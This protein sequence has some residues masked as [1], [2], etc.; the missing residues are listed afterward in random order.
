MS[1]FTHLHVHSHYSLLDGLSKISELVARAKQMGM[2][3]LALTDHGVM[4]G[5]IEFYNSCLEAGIKPII[6][7]EAYIAPRSLADKSGKVDSDYFHLT[8]LAANDKG[9]K[10]LLKLT[11]IAHI[12]GYYYKPR[13]DLNVLRQ[14]SSGLIALSGCQ[15]GELARA[16][17]NKSD[18]EIKE[19]LKKYL[20]IFGAENFYIEIQR[21]SLPA[22]ALAKAGRVQDAAEQK[23]SQ[24]L[25]ALARANNLKIVATADC[26]YIYPNDAEA[27]DVLLCIGTARI[28]SDSNRMDM[29]GYDLSLKTGDEMLE[30]FQDIPESVSNTAEV[31]SRCDLKILTGQR[32]FPKVE[33]PAGK[34]IAEYLRELT[35][36]KALPLYG[37]NGQIPPEI[38]ERI[39]YE[40]NIIIKTGFD[41]YILMVADVVEGAHKLGA[42]TNTRGSAA[43]SIVGRI[44][45]I[46][47]VDPLYYELPFERFYFSNQIERI[48]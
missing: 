26:H 3:S 2:E 36:E 31:A 37:K 33:V 45:G 12:D 16:V 27:Q 7:V 29:R 19:V 35:Y 8:L 43:G 47:N 30:R 34:T 11:T 10:N 44:L 1:K 4:Y 20:D 42:I 15:R 21:N 38:Q 22:E 13:I 32:Y 40:L 39:D 41:T 17:M 25:I 5:A 48:R 14:H 28:T 46:T 24:K 23:L 6:G 18:A 9:Y